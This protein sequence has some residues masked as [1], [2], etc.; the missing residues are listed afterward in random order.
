METSSSTTVDI[1][2]SVTVTYEGDERPRI[3]Q[4]QGFEPH[5]KSF[6]VLVHTVRLSWVFERHAW[7]ERART[8]IGVRVR[9]DGSEGA[10]FRPWDRI[11]DDAKPVRDL[12][13]AL[14]DEHRPTFIPT[15]DLGA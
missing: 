7:R 2:H 11:H 5:L 12:T 9:K 6:D 13:D 10:E 3:V 15:V 1:R 14:H 4:H 8:V